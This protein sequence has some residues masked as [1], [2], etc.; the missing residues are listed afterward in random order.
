MHSEGASPQTKGSTT[1]RSS[2]IEWWYSIR[3]AAMSPTLMGTAS[4]L[5][6]APPRSS[7]TKGTNS[8]RGSYQTTTFLALSFSASCL[9]IYSYNGCISLDLRFLS[10]RALE[11]GQQT[12]EG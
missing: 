1:V 5:D 3:R 7:A 4:S 11:S 9:E 2:N 10:W 8:L 12:S 6:R